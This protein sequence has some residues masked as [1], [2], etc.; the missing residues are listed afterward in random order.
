[1]MITIV[2]A[3]I[4][5]TIGDIDEAERIVISTQAGRTAQTSVKTLDE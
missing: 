3:T 4:T 1:M 2:H 5:G